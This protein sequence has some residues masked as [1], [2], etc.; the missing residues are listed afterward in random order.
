[1]KKNKNRITA[2]EIVLM[3]IVASIAIGISLSATYLLNLIAK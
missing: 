3:I 1:M 2:I